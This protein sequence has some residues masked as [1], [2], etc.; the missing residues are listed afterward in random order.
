[1]DKKI[2]RWGTLYAA[3]SIL[4]WRQTRINGLLKLSL[5][6]LA[7]SATD[8]SQAADPFVVETVQQIRVLKLVPN[9][10]RPHPSPL[11]QE[12]EKPT[13]ASGYSYQVEEKASGRVGGSMEE[14]GGGSGRGENGPRDRQ[15]ARYYLNFY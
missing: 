8:E 14:G 1:M 5:L 15:G 4:S 10:A 9:S 6:G 13:T 7:E 11:P 2:S 12:R 3:E